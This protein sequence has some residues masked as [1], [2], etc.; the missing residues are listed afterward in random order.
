[1]ILRYFQWVIKNLDFEL[2]IYIYIYK[3]VKDEF[4]NLLFI[5]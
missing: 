4:G 5:K 1:M 3:D 2:D